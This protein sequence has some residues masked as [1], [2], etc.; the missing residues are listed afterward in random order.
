MGGGG[1]L[2]ADLAELPPTEHEHLVTR[3]LEDAMEYLG[4]RTVNHIK[5][6]LKD[7]LT[8]G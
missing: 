6:N 3:P 7:Y 5:D 2:G 8:H 4:K 1:R